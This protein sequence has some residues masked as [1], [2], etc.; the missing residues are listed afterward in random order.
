MVRSA[1]GQKACCGVKG[2]VQGGGQNRVCHEKVRW[3]LDCSLLGRRVFQGETVVRVRPQGRAPGSC[4][5]FHSKC[6]K[7][8]TGFEQKSTSGKID[9]PWRQ[10]IK[11]THCAPRQSHGITA[12][13][14]VCLLASTGG[15]VCLQQSTPRMQLRVG[16][17]QFLVFSLTSQFVGQ[18]AS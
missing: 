8:D 1:E 15:G 11:S 2:R 3:E 16:W 5:A 14:G 9:L 4:F 12:G 6:G 7:G 17:K 10:K 13:G 18:S